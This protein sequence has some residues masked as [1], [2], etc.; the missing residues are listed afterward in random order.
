LAVLNRL[1]PDQVHGHADVNRRPTS[2]GGDYRP[3]Q[4]KPSGQAGA[5]SQGQTEG[6]SLRPQAS[7]DDTIVFMQWQHDQQVADES[8]V[9]QPA[10]HGGWF[11]AVVSQTREHFRVIYDADNGSVEECFRDDLPAGLPLEVREQS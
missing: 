4:A 11:L 1:W 2:I 6:P 8:L 5:I 7:N 3:T 9:L 10:M